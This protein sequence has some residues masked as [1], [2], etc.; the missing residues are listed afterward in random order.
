MKWQKTPLK[1]GL[2]FRLNFQKALNPAK[3][4]YSHL[5]M[6]LSPLLHNSMI[7]LIALPIPGKL[8]VKTYKAKYK[9]FLKRI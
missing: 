6:T 4:W 8:L 2:T 7:S 1:I 3:V 5:E 9:L